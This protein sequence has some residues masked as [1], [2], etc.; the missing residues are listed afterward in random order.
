MPRRTSP[1]PGS[2]LVRLH[3]T[4]TSLS[5]T[6]SSLDLIVLIASVYP[7]GTGKTAILRTIAPNSHRLS[8]R[9]RSRPAAASHT[10]S[11]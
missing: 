7:V 11:A 2:P 10:A 5:L 9:R 1:K 4:I 8:P 3:S 6:S